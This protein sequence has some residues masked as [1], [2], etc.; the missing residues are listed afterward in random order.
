MLTKQKII[1]I[2]GS[3]G[4]GLAVAEA[5]LNA[6]AHVIIASRS[7]KKLAAA[8]KSLNN[9]V[10]TFVVDTQQPSTLEALFKSVGKFDHL[11]LPGSEVH[12]GNFQN[13][14][15]EDARAS[16]E[17]KFWGVYSAI[18]LAVP[19][20]NPQG[21]I[22]LYSG[23]ATQKPLKDS[24]FILTALNSAVEGLTRSLAVSL[25]TIRVN[26]ISPGLTLTPIFSQ[27]PQTQQDEILNSLKPNLLIKRY[28]K[29]EEV[30]QAALYLMTNNYMTGQ[31]LT[32]DGGMTT[33]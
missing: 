13:L 27:L 5:A 23:T 10:D 30:A 6:N 32:I 9:A 15:M 26:A 25:E 17:S 7:E 16:F 3:S 22:T 21:S 12:G 19:H 20:I 29:P 24:Y 14:S 31:V 18:K 4:I 1:I 28:G 2:G 11:Q 8:K 33:T